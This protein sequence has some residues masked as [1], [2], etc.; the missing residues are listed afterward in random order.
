MKKL[1]PN[2]IFI[3]IFFFLKLSSTSVAN[4][5]SNFVNDITDKA[6]NILAN[7]VAGFF[8]ASLI[9]SSKHYGILV[10]KLKDYFTKNAVDGFSEFN[11]PVN[12]LVVKQTLKSY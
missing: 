3:I 4:I 6:T 5:S 12:R 1:R 7:Q 2:I 9:L 11:L 8:Y 10:S